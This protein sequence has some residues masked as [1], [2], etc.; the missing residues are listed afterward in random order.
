MKDSTEECWQTVVEA[1]MERNE[2][3]AENAVAGGMIEEVYRGYN[4]QLRSTGHLYQASLWAKDAFAYAFG[5]CRGQVPPDLYEG[6]Y[7]RMFGKT[8]DDE[9]WR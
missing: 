5:Q 7:E 8:L 4:A 3:H 2:H 9:E 6:F 1:L